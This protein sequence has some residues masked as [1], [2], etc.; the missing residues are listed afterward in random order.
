[1]DYISQFFLDHK[2]VLRI[3]L[4]QIKRKTEDTHAAAAAAA[5]YLDIARDKML[6]CAAAVTEVIPWAADTEVDILIWDDFIKEDV[7]IYIDK[8]IYV[9]YNLGYVYIID[10]NGNYIKSNLKNTPDIYIS[11]IESFNKLLAKFNTLFAE[12]YVGEKI[13][14]SPDAYANFRLV[15]NIWIIVPING[16]AIYTP[17]KKLHMCL[18]SI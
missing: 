7:N 5:V 12:F 18:Q 2:D 15:N 17:Q 11:D 16:I 10:F 3:Y 9:L 14:I 8:D 6:C 13:L 1:M 4:A